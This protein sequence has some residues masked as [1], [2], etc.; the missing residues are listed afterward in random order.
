MVDTQQAAGVVAVAAEPSVLSGFGL[1][2]LV[3]GV[4]PAVGQSWDLPVDDAEGV[5]ER[6]A[7]ATV[8]P[9][10]FAAGLTVVTAAGAAR[11]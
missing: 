7:F 8:V 3:V 11:R 2:E 6:C 9:V 1:G 5:I 10:E 4:L